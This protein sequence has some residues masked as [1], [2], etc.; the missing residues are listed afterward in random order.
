MTGGSSPLRQFRLIAFGATIS[1][2]ALIFAGC[3]EKEEW[4][5][6]FQGNALNPASVETVFAAPTGRTFSDRQSC[7]SEIYR[8]SV[9]NNTGLPSGLIDS[10]HREIHLDFFCVR[11][12]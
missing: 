6:Y 2:V 12:R 10:E 9:L 1:G 8:V 11:T 7:I 5:L 4:Q 3:R